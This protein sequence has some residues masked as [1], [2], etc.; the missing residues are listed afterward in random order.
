MSKRMRNKRNRKKLI[1]NI[2]I[3]VVAAAVIVTAIILISK[4]RKDGH[5]MNGFEREAT[6]ARA[7]G[8]R[9]SMI[10]YVLIY[11]MNN[12]RSTVTPQ[13]DEDY[14]QLQENAA[15]QALLVKIYRKEAKALG[16]SLSEEDRQA[17]EEAADNEIK[18]IEDSITQRLI[19]GGGYS[20]QAFEK[21]LTEQFDAIGMSRGAYHDFIYDY[22]ASS[23]YA[24]MI[25]DYYR[26]NGSDIDEAELLRFYRE[27][28][29]KTMTIENEDGTKESA[30]TDDLFWQTMLYYAAGISPTPM[31]YVPEGFIYIDFIQVKTDSVP[32]ARILAD[33]IKK[34]EKSFDELMASEENMDYYRNVMKAPYPIAEKDHSALFASQEIYD[35][36]AGLE[37][38]EIGSFIGEPVKGQ[39]G[40]ETVPL[41][42][43]RRAEGTICGGSD[44]GIID[45]DVFTGMR[46]LFE[47]EYRGSKWF[48]DI[49]FSDAIYSYKGVSY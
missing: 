10:E 24:E 35:L 23:K 44:H 27:S 25:G 26:E 31:L 45:I 11:D 34:G 28:V 1:R 15:K 4:L 9:V 8:E 46:E 30:Y 49:E 40:T 5:G 6:A 2:L 39:D 47:N 41:Y 14:R 42:L 17:C 37:V 21:M 29:E 19:A 33:Q 16:L 3:A 38:G 7:D 43:F 32:D 20:R 22:V 13:T 12:N 18:S 48:E 36:A